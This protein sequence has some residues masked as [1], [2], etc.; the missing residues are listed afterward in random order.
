MFWSC[1]VCLLVS[2]QAAKVIT[3][4][5]NSTN[6]LLEGVNIVHIY[7]RQA[8]Q[9]YHMIPYGDYGEDK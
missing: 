7:C 5:E 8:E 4:A 6:W 2:N 1:T 3:A 9:E